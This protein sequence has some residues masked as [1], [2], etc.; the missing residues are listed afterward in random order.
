MSTS[1]ILDADWYPQA[2]FQ[3]IPNLSNVIILLD[4]ST[5]ILSASDNN[6]IEKF[7]AAEHEVKFLQAG[8]S[9]T[10][11]WDSEPG[12][13]EPS[14]PRDPGEV[15]ED[16][17]EGDEGKPEEPEPVDDDPDED[18]DDDMKGGPQ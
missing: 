10:K 16:H 18:P 7:T 15:P 11:P 5:S 3:T 1:V 2:S 13:D 17:K 8:E 9:L 4:I 6:F 14:L 12:L